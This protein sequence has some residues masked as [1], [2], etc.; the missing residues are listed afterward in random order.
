MS[1]SLHGGIDSSSMMSA[2]VAGKE[3]GSHAEPSSKRHAK[4]KPARKSTSACD[5]PGCRSSAREIPFETK[6]L[7]SASSSSSS[8]I[9]RALL[10]MVCLVASFPAPYSAPASAVASA[11][12]TFSISACTLKSAESTDGEPR[13]ASSEVLIFAFSACSFR[14]LLALKGA[15]DA[16]PCLVRELLLLLLESFGVCTALGGVAVRRGLSPVSLAAGLASED[17][18]AVSGIDLLAVAAPASLDCKF[19]MSK[20]SCAPP[21]A[22]SSFNSARRFLRARC[23]S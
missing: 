1:V 8:S 6:S 3:P 19:A 18:C 13:A 5:P 12:V 22:S 23:C 14:K 15:G 17:P 2:Q 4:I 7:T 10:R 9:R 16:F 11:I 20:L 21:P